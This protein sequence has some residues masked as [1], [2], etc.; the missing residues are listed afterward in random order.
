MPF[1]TQGKTN[2]KY[3]LI[4]VIL[5]VVVGGGALWY[6]MKKEQPYQPP[7]VKK[8]QTSK[9]FNLGLDEEAKIIY[10]F[11][12][13]TG[14]T[15]EEFTLSLKK[16]DLSSKKVTFLKY[17]LVEPEISIGEQSFCPV[18]EEGGSHFKL[19]KLEE[20]KA[21]FETW[22]GIG[23]PHPLGPFLP[24]EIIITKSTE[25]MGCDWRL[26]KDLGLCAAVQGFY[27]DGEKC[28]AISGC[29]RDEEAIPFQTIEE[30]KALCEETAGWKTP[31]KELGIN[32]ELPDEFIEVF[33]IPHKTYEKEGKAG[34]AINF[35]FSMMND[36]RGLMLTAYTSDYEPPLNQSWP[37]DEW[38]GKEDVIKTCPKQLEYSSNRVCKIINIGQEKAIFETS[39]SFLEESCSLNVKVYFNNRSSSLYKGLNFYISLE[40]VRNKVCEYYYLTSGGNYSEEFKSELYAQLKNIMENKNLSEEDEKRLELFEQML[41]AFRFLD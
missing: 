19:I 2:W 18:T 32:L 3:I 40:D 14:V 25:K 20:N 34:K 41:S 5:A 13:G 1:L 29:G 10:E 26:T 11:E 23:E 7:T 21:T 37:F 22:F 27:Y 35:D 33:G 31:I 15:K 8:T 6:S 12:T 38:I 39:L 24:K 36:Y 17:C 4:V 28:V 30:C 9:E 16:I